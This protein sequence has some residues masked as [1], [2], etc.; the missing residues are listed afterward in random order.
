[1]KETIT[2]KAKQDNKDRLETLLTATMNIITVSNIV[3]TVLY[4]N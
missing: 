4:L 1:M 3:Y 2:T